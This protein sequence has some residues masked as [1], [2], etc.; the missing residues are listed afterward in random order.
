M[1]H[2]LT[3]ITFQIML[4]LFHALL[5]LQLPRYQHE[6]L[7]KRHPR[8]RKVSTVFPNC[9]VHRLYS[10]SGRG[11]RQKNTARLQ[12]GLAAQ[13]LNDDGVERA[14]RRRRGETSTLS[15]QAAASLK[16]NTGT[17]Q[18]ADIPMA[19][20]NSS[21]DNAEYIASD[22]EDSDSTTDTD[23]SDSER[24]LTNIEVRRLATYLI[25]FATKFLSACRNIDI[26][27]HS[28]HVGGSN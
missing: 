3:G 20:A 14:A 26:Q 1:H 24:V 9:Y 6:I 22:D 8:H 16:D 21:E 23:N 25:W 11:Y 2:K 12:A 7:W 19:E 10:F 5:H 13:K 18:V 4:D 28:S 15:T 27:D 17:G